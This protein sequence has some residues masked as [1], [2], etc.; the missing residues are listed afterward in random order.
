[1]IN[2]AGFKVLEKI[3]GGSHSC[4]Y[5]GIRLSDG[6]SVIIKTPTEK[7]VP[8]EL[9][10]RFR[11]EFSIGSRFD[12]KLIIKYYQLEPY[13]NGLA[14]ISEDFGGVKLSDLIPE[15]GMSVALFLDVAIQITEGLGII[16]GKNVIH[17]DLKPGNI[18]ISPENHAIK[19]L[20]FG[21]S[22]QA[23]LESFQGIDLAASGGT[24]EY[25]SPEQTGRTNRLIDYRSDLYSLGVT[26]YRMACGSVPFVSDDPLELIHSHIAKTPSP[27]AAHRPDIFPAISNIIMKL[28]QKNAE[29]RYQSAEGVKADL[30]KCRDQF[31]AGGV[32]REFEIAKADFSGK[33]KISQKLYGREQET[34]RLLTAFERVI[35]G[36]SELILVTGYSGVGK[37]AVIGELQNPVASGHGYFISG[38]YDQFTRGSAYSAIVHAF[39]GLI[40][41]ILGEP[42]AR[43]T[44][45]REKLLASLGEN[46]RI[47][48][49][50]I[51]SL[52]KI[53]G[54]QPATRDLG[55]VESQ[56]RF[57]LTFGKFIRVF[58]KAEHPLV[59]FLDDIQNADFASI[60]QIKQFATDPE[61]NHFMLVCAYRDN[62]VDGSHPVQ[63]ALHEIEKIRGSI[64]RIAL[65][66]LDVDN[67]GQLVADALGCATGVSR[68]LADEI[69]RKTGGNA[70]FVKLFLQT[71]YEDQLLKFASPA[72]WQWNIEDIR[73]MQATDNVADLM[74]RKLNSFPEDTRAT[75]KLAACLGNTWEIETLALSTGHTLEQVR[76]DLLPV[77]NM[78]M[79]I[80]GGGSFRFV[81]DKIHEG[82]YSLIPESKKPAVHL[83]IGEILLEHLTDENDIKAVVSVVNH[84]NIAS[85]LISDTQKKMRVARLN[86]LAGQQ[87]KK[88]TAYATARQY[89]IA[90]IANLPE[91]S[92]EVECKLCY[93]LHKEWAEA[94][95]LNGD[96]NKSQ[97][98]ISRLLDRSDS[99]ISKTELYSML[100]YQY[101]VTADYQKGIATGREALKLLGVRLP[102][103]NLEAALHAEI[104]QAKHNLGNREIDTLI[105]SPAMVSPAH[106]AAMRI[107]MEMQPTTYMSDPA[108]Y[109]VIAVMMANLSLRYGHTHESAKAYVTYANVLSSVLH[110]YH[111]GY[112]FCRLGLK[113]SERYND[114][115]QKCRGSFIHTAFLLHWT[116]PFREGDAAFEEGYQTGIECGDFQYA[117]YTVGFGTAN[118]YNKGMRL[119]R[120]SKKL[121]RFMS[122]AR[123]AKHQMPIDTI[124]GFQLAIG[125]LR[126]DT[127]G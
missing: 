121:D 118:L 72:G 17:K 10:N 59:M 73:E 123:K 107:L 112:E 64:G 14:I 88:N 61:L 19:Y 93:A 55:P 113:M 75:L 4:A 22:S 124:Q 31:T 66:P 76:M 44:V 40:H 16:H 103:N 32:I 115:V 58:A 41:L 11:S 116:R 42:E 52:E 35:K 47:I 70:F 20:D 98:I 97:K 96:F 25:I 5:R 65:S 63:S 27:L 111:S 74:L 50:I 45:W 114:P 6:K 105:D 28:L 89:F 2:I 18:A 56:N 15:D 46:A 83:H 110:E 29:D 53:I 54:L 8:L 101:T 26:L 84:L 3:S 71:L 49:D 34:R 62:E 102:D 51:P 68:P 94:E 85:A 23:E 91:L 12:S 108:L 87:S 109:G 24:I 80:Q 81:H 95:Y 43:I 99:V 126:G 79:I 30:E 77:L 90:G 67:T 33:F 125:N 120:L 92:W 21:I 100:V 48:I 106:Q 78:G 1:M 9:I 117:G 104:Q 37:S 36:K 57:D 38:K 69:H 119:E 39:Q 127:D 122:F 82:A 7:F 86:L 60:K 13:Q